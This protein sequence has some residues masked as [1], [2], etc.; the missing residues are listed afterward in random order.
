MH[1]SAATLTSMLMQISMVLAI[2]LSALILA[3]GQA[4]AGHSEPVLLN[5]QVALVVMGI[6]VTAASMLCLQLPRDAGAEVSGH[7]VD[8]R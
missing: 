5:F 8:R 7:R 4:A 6:V 1:S 3:V 2:A